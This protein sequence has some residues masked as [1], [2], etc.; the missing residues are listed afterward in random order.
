MLMLVM[1]VGC[2]A[3][4]MDG[5]GGLRVMS[6]NIRIGAGGGDWPADTRQFNLEP[7]ARVIDAHRL[8]L[9]GLQEVD[10]FRPRSALMDQPALL[11]QRLGMNAVF[12]PAY[13]VPVQNAPDEEYGVALLAEHPVR[14]PTRFP[15]YKPD[16][17]Q[18][19]P[20]YPDYFSEQRVLLYAPVQIRR[21]T[22]HVFVTHLGLT[23]DQR[24]R[25]IAQIVEITK[26]HPGPIILMG[27]FNAEPSETA[28]RL[29]G[30]R[31]QD[32]LEAVGTT[33]EDRKSFPAGLGPR[34]AIDYIFVSKHFEVV[35][36]KVVRDVSVASDHNPVIAELRLK[37]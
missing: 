14:K 6:Y 7:A 1:L 16:Y 32:A 33:A 30:D 5:A 26:R 3:P 17:R 15:L 18:S 12:T 13:T 25:Q 29:L 36:A 9:V 23:P 4:R 27:D 8:D 28:M 37:P 34:T 24:E 11:Q 21:H 19:H 20:E 22:I 31:F 35:S 2:R 10:R